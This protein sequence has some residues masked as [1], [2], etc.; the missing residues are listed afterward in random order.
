MLEDKTYILLT[1]DTEA[2]MY[3]GR[4]L[5]ISKMVYGE[6]D[7]QE[8]GISKIMDICEMYGFRATFFISV[9]EYL[10]FGEEA[11]KEICRDIYKRGHDV[12]LHTHPKWKYDRK[13]MW[14]Y[15]MDEQ[16]EIIQEGKEK[17]HQWI[18]VEPIAHRA[19]GFGANYDTLPAL[20][21]NGILI[22]CSL[23]SHYPFCKL[24]DNSLRENTVFLIGGVVEVPLTVFTQF[25]L[26]NIR[27][28]RNFDLN[29]DTL[30]E[31]INVIKQGRRGGIKTLTLLLHSFSLL[32]RDKTRTKF[33]PNLKDLTKFEKLLNYI[34]NDSNLEV[35]TIKDFY[36]LY[37]KNPESF[38]SPDF[39]PNSGLVR[40]FVRCCKHFNSRY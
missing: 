16:A 32:N 38:Q 39:V 2:S 15:T 5:P 24:N 14:E 1:V 25:R 17:I 12:Q 40:T 34:K 9:L 10:H 11:I 7:G 27:P 8:Y 29:A 36:H 13:F 30:S 6:I 37:N 31:L 35:I 26:G 3:K 23:A 22:D 20:Q 18:G 19:G 21:R 33:E 4:P 28:Y